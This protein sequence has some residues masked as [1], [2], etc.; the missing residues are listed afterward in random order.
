MPVDLRAHPAIISLMEACGR[1]PRREKLSLKR[2][3]DRV[4]AEGRSTAD[5]NI[6]VYVLQTQLGHPR[7][8]LAVGKGIGKAV[9]RNRVKRL[10]REAYRLNRD[11]LPESAD[12]VVIAR[13]SV[14]P[15]FIEISASLVERAAR[16]MREQE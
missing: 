1:F 10:I 14:H 13:K 12:I 8:G 16:L 7:L 11:S 2:D 4:F 5:D 3:F 15:N 9:A 6:V